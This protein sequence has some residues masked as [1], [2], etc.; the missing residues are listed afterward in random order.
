[1]S[2]FDF[3][4]FDTKS[5]TIEF[6]CDNC[7]AVVISDDIFIPSPNYNAERVS[8]SQVEEEAWVNC[9]SCEKEFEIYI[10]VTYAGGSGEVHN[11]SKDQDVTVNE[12][13]EDF[14]WEIE[15]TKQLEIFKTHMKS[16][17]KLI[18]IQFDE[19][20]K[21][22]LLVMLYAHVVTATEYF[23]SSVFIREVTISDDFTKKLIETDQELAKIKFSLK[24]IYQQNDFL[25]FTVAKYLND[26]IFHNLI[27]VKPMYKTVLDFD[28]GDI[29]WFFNAV[30]KRHDCV[31]RA[32]YDKENKQIS[33][34]IQ[35][36]SELIKNC[37]DLVQSIE[38]HIIY[39]LK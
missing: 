9:N 18:T 13:R 34:S 24:E 39:K 33:L 21:F 7:G 5:I 35:E 1:M 29:A 20:T 14:Y 6:K 15:S 30:N 31:H 23:L 22:S 3:N 10:Y 11:L 16:I 8:D 19:I 36:I 17:E 37:N 32:G 25:K 28:F 38:K 2:Y 27:K 26:L 4:S 12:I